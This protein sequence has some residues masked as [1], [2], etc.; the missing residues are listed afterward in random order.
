MTALSNR[1]DRPS[2]SSPF[3]SAGGEPSPNTSEAAE[4]AALFLPSPVHPEFQGPGSVLLWND[5]ETPRRGA[6]HTPGA[7]LRDSHAFLASAQKP[8][9]QSVSFD[10]KSATT[11]P[12]LRSPTPPDST[13]PSPYSNMGSDELMNF[14]GLTSPVLSP[15][16]SI[17]DFEF[18]DQTSPLGSEQRSP[19]KK[20]DPHA[21]SER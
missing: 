2:F 1:A 12:H 11:T 19:E 14:Q 10:L 15:S 6:S 13:L 3:A 18:G 8:K 21:R 5:S 17:L 4:A 16:E 7:T 9:G 20:A